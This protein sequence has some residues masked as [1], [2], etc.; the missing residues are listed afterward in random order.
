VAEELCRWLAERATQVDV[1][2]REFP[3]DPAEE[4][5]DT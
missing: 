4:S 5:R 2:H 1:R 3:F